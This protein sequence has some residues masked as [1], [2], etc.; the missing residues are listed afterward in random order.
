MTRVNAQVNESI[1]LLH[2]G[3]TTVQTQ[4]TARSTFMELFLFKE[5][6]ALPFPLPLKLIHLTI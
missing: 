5:R 4:H 3:A 1:A 6:R 2:Y